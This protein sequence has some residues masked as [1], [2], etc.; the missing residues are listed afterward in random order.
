MTVKTIPA[1]EARVHLGEIMKKSFKS[2]D[3][4]IVEKAGIPMVAIISAQ[5]Y[6][7]LVEEREER[8]RIL[9][10]IKHKTPVISEEEA[11]KDIEEA[12]K[13]VRKKRA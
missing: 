2:G 3:C 4:F 1:L 7:H 5:E 10:S 12:L 11:Q 13:N 9:D 6:T 8:F